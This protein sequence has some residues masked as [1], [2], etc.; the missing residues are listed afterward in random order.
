MALIDFEGFD[1]MTTGSHSEYAH[2]SWNSSSPNM[3]G[4]TTTRFSVGKSLKKSQSTGQSLIRSL[5]TGEQHA[6]IIVGAAFYHGASAGSGIIYELQSDAG[7]TIHTR[8]QFNGAGQIQITR[9]ST[10]LATS[11][12]SALDKI[13]E[14]FYLEVKAVLGDTTA[15]SISV[16]MNNAVVV[17]ISGTD[18]KNG[19]TKTVYDRIVIGMLTGSSSR[20]IDDIY[21][22]NGAGSVNNDFMGEVRCYAIAPNANG[23]Y[24]QFDGSDGNSTD[25]YLLVDDA[26]PLA[27]G[28]ISDYVGTAVDNE[29]DTYGFADQTW[30]GSIR[31]VMVRGQAQKTD[32]GAKSIAFV[33]RTSS[34]D[35][36]GTDQ[37]LGTSWGV[38]TRLMEVDPATTSA[39]TLSNFNAYEFG[40][41]ARP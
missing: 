37:A 41:K 30:P 12:S 22:A 19:G 15:G 2:G 7:G 21:I 5:D 40:V 38:Y 36:D 39:W 6:T 32:A 9:G 8:V 13:G 23:N 33:G 27:A 35:Y 16:R 18:T 4:D 1:N 17:S 14:W 34:T 31:G 20:Y 28:A 3:E 24:S 11:A 26:L 10:V 25:N 29:Y